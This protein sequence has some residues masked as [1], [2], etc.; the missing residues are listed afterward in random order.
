M[1]A[2]LTSI[3]RPPPQVRDH[4]NSA[5]SRLKLDDHGLAILLQTP[6][7]LS[8][9]SES[10]YTPSFI[11]VRQPYGSDTVH[12]QLT[13]TRQIDELHTLSSTVTLSSHA[14]LPDA[15]SVP[16]PSNEAAAY[17]QCAYDT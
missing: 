16:P 11:T 8:S 9:E 1:F 10:L 14:R 12:I 4:F 7:F 6:T 17:V 2:S 15:F 3:T 5:A 13:Q